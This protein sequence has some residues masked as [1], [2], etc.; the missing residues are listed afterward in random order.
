MAAC[1]N[2]VET[3]SRPN[4]KS[5]EG[6]YMAGSMDMR[7]RVPDAGEESHAGTAEEVL[8]KGLQ[9][10]TAEAWEYFSRAYE[11]AML[12][13]IRRALG[14]AGRS[15]DEVDRMAQFVRW[16]LLQHAQVLSAFDP[17]R[18]NL[19]AF[20]VAIARRTVRY[21]LRKPRRRK[22]RQRALRADVVQPPVW[23]G[24]DNVQ[25]G[26]CAAIFA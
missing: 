21:Q 2:N 23:D 14:R 26:E 24:L 8:V 1:F 16:R 9:A 18:G 13:A 3:A 11:P 22:I 7:L 15:E 20:L 19:T 25:L 12:D 4:G 10:G 5:R 17:R 6:S